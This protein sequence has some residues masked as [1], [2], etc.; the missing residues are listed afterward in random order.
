MSQSHLLQLIYP[1]KKPQ[2]LFESWK[3]LFM[4]K[5]PYMEVSLEVPKREL[6][7]LQTFIDDINELDR[8]IQ[9][10]MEDLIAFLYGNL[11]QDARKGKLKNRPF[12]DKLL[13]MYKELK[14]PKMRET[15]KL[16]SPNQM[17]RIHESIPR[18]HSF[19]YYPIQLQKKYVLRGEVLL[20]DLYD[21]E[22]EKIGIK[23]ADLITLLLIEFSDEIR[24][25]PTQKRIQTI[26][27]G[28]SS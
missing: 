15:W 6:L 11:I 12:A 24:K 22:K 28:L 18:S 23:V 5:S 2:G 16:V 27:K 21:E 14:E 9:F 26:L 3:Q 4:E 7:R 10:T 13:S 20:M 25:G 1:E 8:D 19:V 17:S